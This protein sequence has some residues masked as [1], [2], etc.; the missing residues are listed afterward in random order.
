MPTKTAKK[1]G[2]PSKPASQKGETFSVRLQ[3]DLR[4]ALAVSA[5]S[6]GRSLNA[7]ITYRLARSL[8]DESPFQAER[9]LALKQLRLAAV[10][11]SLMSEM[12]DRTEI[13]EKILQDALEDLRLWL[14]QLDKL[15]E[16]EER[17]QRAAMEKFN[18]E[19]QSI[20]GMLAKGPGKPKK[21]FME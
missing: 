14:R 15:Q 7:E 17:A 8:A 11:V 4:N 18:N 13:D 12:T 6:K 5:E 3:P 9:A 16:E 20:G 10:S 19:L 1:P 2:R 21:G